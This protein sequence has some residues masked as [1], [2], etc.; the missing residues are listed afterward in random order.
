MGWIS[1]GHKL[2]CF[3]KTDAFWLIRKRAMAKNGIQGIL[4][5]TSVPKFK[6]AVP[7]NKPKATAKRKQKLIKG[8]VKMYFANLKIP[9]C[10][11]ILIVK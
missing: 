5:L 2:F 9:I 6:V 8:S 4:Y 10:N 1:Q 3:F 7:T 11:K